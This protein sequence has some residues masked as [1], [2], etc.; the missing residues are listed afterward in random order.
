MPGSSKNEQKRAKNGRNLDFEPHFQGNWSTHNHKKACKI[1]L[2]D[3]QNN[4]LIYK[5][6]FAVSNQPN[7]KAPL[8]RFA[9]FNKIST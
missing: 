5:L 3:I 7:Q 8:L 4:K 1:D 2:L 6:G 9:C